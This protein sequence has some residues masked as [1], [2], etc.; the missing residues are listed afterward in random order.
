MKRNNVI[1]GWVK[2]MSVCSPQN[3]RVYI[4][5]N[6]FETQNKKLDFR[7]FKIM[8]VKKGPEAAE[9]KEK[10][11][12]RVVPRNILIKEFLNYRMKDDDISGFDGI[13]DSILDLLLAFRLLKVGDI[14]FGDLLIEDMEGHDSWHNPYSVAR[15]SFFKYSFGHDEIENFNNFRDIIANKVGYG[16]R[17][18]KFSLNHFMSGVDKSF[19]YKIG[20]LERIVDYVVALESLFLIDSQLY[21]LRHT[22]TERISTLLK[23][24]SVR[25]IVKFMYDER[26]KIVHGSNIGLSE[27]K[28]Q[29]KIEKIKAHM[30]RF[31]SLMREVFLKLLDFSFSRKEEIV[32]FMKELYDVPSESLRMMQSAK[33]KAEKYL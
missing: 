8:S 16:N 3:F 5:I 2:R 13:I 15:P 28:R 24:D 11:G 10:L 4:L 26:S 21:F 17:F 18:Y 30:P 25:K 32:K 19:F 7:D 9:W 20:N 6:N 29:R 1:K 22:I 14:V 33:E 31:E 27:N 23:D 12:C